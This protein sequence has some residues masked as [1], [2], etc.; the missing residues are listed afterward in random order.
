M[1]GEVIARQ[2]DQRR[3]PQPPHNAREHSRP[4]AAEG[5]EP[6]EQVATPAEFLPKGEDH[7]DRQA[8]REGFH[9]LRDERDLGE[10]VQREPGGQ[11]LVGSGQLLR[12]QPLQCDHWVGPVLIADEQRE[13]D[14]RGDQEGR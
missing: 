6:R 7:V 12:D 2:H 5:G 9:Q 1:A 10:L 14:A 8:N 11:R 4:G 3:V 13:P